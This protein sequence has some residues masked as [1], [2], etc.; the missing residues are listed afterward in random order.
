VA[1]VGLTILVCESTSQACQAI[2]TIAKFLDIIFLCKAYLTKQVFKRLKYYSSEYYKVR[3][4]ER[5]NIVSEE[6]G[7]VLNGY[8]GRTLLKTTDAQILGARSPW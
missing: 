8:L 1:V 4:R 5:V 2:I 3:E 6:R 7:N